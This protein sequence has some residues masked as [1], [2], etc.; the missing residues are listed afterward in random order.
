M[1][2]R[3]WQKSMIALARSPGVKSFM[4]GNRAATALA[5]RFVAGECVSDGV[6]RARALLDAHRIRSS[7]FYLGEYLDART[8]VA[9]SVVNK[10]AVAEAL[11]RA[12]LDV[13]IS[14]DPTQIG[15]RQNAT[16]CKQNLTK[17]AESVARSS[18]SVAGVHCAMLDMEDEA[19][20]DPTIALHN[21]LRSEGL[22]VAL[23]LQAYLRR[24]ERDMRALV[25]TASHVRL[26]NGAFA[27]GRDIAFASRREVKANFRRL[28]ELMVSEEARD[29]GFY[30]SIATHDT[31]LHQHACAI[32]SAR[33][34]QPDQ[35]EFELLLGV[36]TPVAQ[37]LARE[38]W[39][40]RAYVPFGSDWWPHAV[41]RIGENPLNAG[42]LLRSLVSTNA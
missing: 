33:G 37:A 1:S 3:L 20:V 38:G 30:P 35:F 6:E 13:H 32:A 24:T 34:W 18:K 12:G 27:A 25:R 26:V 31:D 29:A 42:L 14:I 22:P 11:G 8:L 15:Q 21:A 2:R 7:L 17:I 5:Q 19:L 41:R 9:E 16:L 39:R 36:R 28:I 10:L 4:Q 23:T 40:V